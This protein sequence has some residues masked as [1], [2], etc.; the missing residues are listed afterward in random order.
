V[1][2]L[3]PVSLAALFSR[4]FGATYVSLAYLGR[5]NLVKALQF[6]GER[7]IFLLVKYFLQPSVRLT[8]YETVEVIG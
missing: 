8:K 3:P 1:I 2:W 4:R 6:L 7:I 5:M